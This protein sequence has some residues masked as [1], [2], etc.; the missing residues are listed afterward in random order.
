[1][2]RVPRASWF[3]SAATA[4]RLSISASALPANSSTRWPSG[5]TRAKARPSR[6]N[7][8]NPSSFSSA[9]RAR[10]IAGCEVPSAVA[11]WVTDRPWRAM[12]IA[13]WSWW[14]FMEVL[15]EQS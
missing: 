2:D 11:A 12:A 5:V 14:K 15:R 6:T 8:S 9:F 10:L 4:F 1:M 3:R 13:Y 7:S